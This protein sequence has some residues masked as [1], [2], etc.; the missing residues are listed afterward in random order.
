MRSTLRQFGG[1]LKERRE[2][3]RSRVLELAAQY[4]KPLVVEMIRQETGLPITKQAV[5]NIITG[6][7]NRHLIAP[8]TPGQERNIAE[9]EAEQQAQINKLPHRCPSCAGVTPGGTCRWCGKP[10]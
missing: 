4:D 3:I 6:Q 7:R 9:V 5:A 10:V 8:I 1:L 2:R